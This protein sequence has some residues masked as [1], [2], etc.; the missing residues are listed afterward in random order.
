MSNKHLRRYLEQKEERRKAEHERQL[1]STEEDNTDGEEVKLENKFSFLVGSSEE[2]S[3]NSEESSNSDENERGF[4]K[5]LKKKKRKDRKKN[6]KK[7]HNSIV[8][9]FP[10]SVNNPVEAALQ[11]SGNLVFESEI[12]KVDLKLL[13]GEAEF[14]KML[15]LRANESQKRHQKRTFGRV[16]KKKST[17]PEVKNLGLSMELE[18]EELN[19]MWFKFIHNASYQT[20]QQTFWLYV[21]AANYQ[22]IQ[23]ILREC[24]YHLD[25]LLV[26]A[27]VM[28][29]QENYQ[30]ARDFIE[31]GIYC[32]E[33]AFSSHFELNNYN[34]RISYGQFENRAFFLL[35]HQHMRN[36]VDRS[37]FLAALNFAKLLYRLDPVDDPLAITLSIDTLAL[38]ARE[39][40]YLFRLYD[41]LKESRC[42]EKLPSFA[43]SLALAHYFL[44]SENGNVDEL[45]KADI[46]LAAAIYHFP[47][48]L[49]QILNKL[50]IQPDSDVESNVYMNTLAHERESEG[51]K[52]LTKVYI[53]LSHDLWKEN[54]VLSWLE[55]AT[56]KAVANFVD[57]TTEVENW[58]KIRKTYVRIPRN[59]QRHGF[60]W[61]ITQNA[62]WT[63]FDPAPPYLSSSTY[64]PQTGQLHASESPFWRLV[65][66]LFPEENQAFQFN[67]VIEQ[68]A[69]RLRHLFA[70]LN[71]GN[72]QPPDD[73]PQ[74]H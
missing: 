74:R 67:N 23:G 25:S 48:V 16:V 12:F 9:D 52:H 73:P 14:R 69:V 66:S 22:G 4:T 45:D 27:E 44:Y 39:Y 13:N 59:V 31:R 70:T 8:Q 51:F 49:V 62:E 56:R 35:L 71:T 2:G 63:L 11:S 61:G 50:N 38:K 68:A 64:A 26:M 5:T 57:H 58:A 46:A 17:W 18:C 3:K 28:R 30:V 1:P 60:L 21:D 65:T 7:L 37:C 42:L 53:E 36:L 41:V 40:V 54:H 33:S 34:H 24:P 47:T 43:Y 6:E 72:A 55:T 32:C 10:S 19:V 15:G 20:F 29:Q